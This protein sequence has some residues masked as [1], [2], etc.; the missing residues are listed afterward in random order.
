MASRC[1]AGIGPLV[2]VALVWPASACALEKPDYGPLTSRLG[3]LSSPKVRGL[4][5]ARQAD[6]AD[7][8]RSGPASLVRRGRRLVV[9]VRFR[10]RVPASV[11]TLRAAGARIVHVS[12]QARVV[13]AAVAARDLRAVGDV[14]GVE[15][16][17]EVLSPLYAQSGGPAVVRALNTCAGAVTS[18]GDAQLNAAAVRGE[19]ELDG[20]G[21]KVGVLADSLGDGSADVASGDLPGAGNPCGRTTPVEVVADTSATN[22]GRAMLQ[23]VHDIAPG[24]NLAFASTDGGQAVVADRIRQLRTSG[25][26][27]IVDGVTFPDEPFFQDGPIGVA[28]DEVTAAGVAYFSPA[29][30]N[31]LVD[32]AGRDAAAWE[33]PLF[34][35]AGAC[36]ALVGA[37]AGLCEDFD[38]AAATD[39]TTEISVGPGASA[40]VVLQ[41]DAPF[42]SAA[43]DYDL[44][45][46]NAADS[47]LLVASTGAQ[48]GND[49]PV[50]TLTI[51]NA[52]ASPAT[53]N[54]R[55]AKFSGANRRLKFVIFQ[56]AA[57]GAF[58]PTLG[59][60]GGD[61]LGPAIVGHNG[62]SGASTVAAVPASDA[63]AVEATSS[64]GPVTRT[65]APD[66]TALAAPLVLDKP[67]IAATDCVHNTFF[68]PGNVFCGT[69][70]AAAH[71]AGVAALQL[72]GNPGLTPAKLRAA[73]ALSGRQ[74]GS[75]GSTAR[76]AGLLDAR[77]AVFAVALPPVLTIADAPPSATNDSTPAIG[78]TAN[79]PVTAS[80]SV[81][82]AAAVACTSPFTAPELP[83][84]P[85]TFAVSGVDAAGHTGTAVPVSFVVDTA[86][87]NARITG[88]PKGVTRKA[89]PTFRFA[90]DEQAV[91]FRCSFD[92]KAFRN[93][94]RRARPGKRLAKGRHRFRVRATDAA[95]NVDASPAK[96][97][98]RVKPRR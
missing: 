43:D 88:G 11:R 81:D 41:W 50:E 3:E 19:M 84:G 86:A 17:T 87:P 59:T 34:R 94:S 83:D 98:F 33:T 28:V 79:R 8:P 68:G 58:F 49:N 44:Y 9:E 6:A 26:R 73:Q 72:Q 10:H 65:L 25:A 67:D 55:I 48:D 40:A 60:Q 7:L 47:V 77:E 63:N 18:E 92:R 1:T 38:P 2:A 14:R 93:C 89:R 42:G 22:Q 15:A 82:G 53:F 35:S 39:Q 30:D 32:P 97:S 46:S 56:N 20:A 71:A 13:T 24:A 96:R 23:L 78:F 5:P 61:V 16:V 51:N 75:F 4:T 29:G 80:C 36:G 91:S 62:A 12:S 69:A 57:P 31:N 64:R 27:V 90:A 85:H 52:T 66:G 45:L 54:L 74:V 21:I 76:G 70:A 95:G 37:G